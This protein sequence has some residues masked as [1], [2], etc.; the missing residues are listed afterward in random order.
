MSLLTQEEL[1]ATPTAIL[2][3]AYGW[4]AAFRNRRSIIFSPNDLANILAIE[5]EL[6]SRET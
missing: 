2:R 6:E 5:K 3:F 1:K 4:L